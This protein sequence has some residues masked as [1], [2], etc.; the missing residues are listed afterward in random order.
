MR[1]PC[2]AA[3]MTLAN[4]CLLSFSIGLE[5]TI[6]FLI[7]QQ[8]DDME[9]FITLGAFLIGG[10]LGWLIGGKLKTG[11]QV[12]R[13]KYDALTQ[14]NTALATRLEITESENKKIE[15]EKKAFYIQALSA[16]A[17]ATAL[18][19]QLLQQRE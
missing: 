12:S 13:T 14:E 5:S 19:Q 3:S 6:K 7:P 2:P 9:S 15:G 10:A 16:E 11:D 17:R 1:V 4:L 8:G 18:E